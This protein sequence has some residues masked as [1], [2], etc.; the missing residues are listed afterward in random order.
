[1]DS[2]LVFEAMQ[3]DPGQSASEPGRASIRITGAQGFRMK[4]GM[5]AGMLMTLSL[6]QFMRGDLEGVEV[7]PAWQDQEDLEA[8]YALDSDARH[9]IHQVV[10]G[11]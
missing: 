4:P 7:E 10:H 8:I 2:K 6:Q 3:E 9:Y 5:Y 11:W 1:M